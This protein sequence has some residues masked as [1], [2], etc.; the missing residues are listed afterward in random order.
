MLDSLVRASRRVL[1]ILKSIA[2]PTVNLRFG[3]SEETALLTA[4]QNRGRHWVITSGLVLIELVA[5]WTQRHSSEWTGCGPI[6]LV[7]RRGAGRANEGLT[8]SPKRRDRR[9]THTGSSLPPMGEVHDYD[10][11]MFDSKVACPRLLAH[12]EHC[13]PTVTERR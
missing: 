13:A 2:S 12:P 9:P 1:R 4:G 3:Q 7:Y 10:A 6:P 11:G 5:G 8:R